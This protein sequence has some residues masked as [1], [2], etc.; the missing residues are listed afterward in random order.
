M[1][2]AP[3]KMIQHVVVLML[4]NRSFDCMLGRLYPSGPTFDGLTG[5]EKNLCNG[6]A[7]PVWTSPSIEAD[8]ACIPTPD[9]NELFEDMTEQL[10]GAGNPR[11]PAADMSGFA[12]N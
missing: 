2:A 1:P 7:V 11:P 6:T 4:E 5:Q 8:V 9:P 10:F 12:A 3:E